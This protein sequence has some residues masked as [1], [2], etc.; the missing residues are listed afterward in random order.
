MLFPCGKVH[1]ADGCSAEER[2]ANGT[3]PRG[4]DP[5]DKHIGIIK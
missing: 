4:T 2:T 3:E 1:I 5:E